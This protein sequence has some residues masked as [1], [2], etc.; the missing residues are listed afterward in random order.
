MAGFRGR[1]VF[2]IEWSRHNITLKIPVKAIPSHDYT[3]GKNGLTFE[4]VF[5]DAGIDER[6]TDINKLKESVFEKLDRWYS[7]DWD[8]YFLV[9]V[10]GGESDYGCTRLE[11]RTF[12]RFRIEFEVEFYVV[13]KDMRGVVR[14]MRIPRPEKI[15]DFKDTRWAGE[16]PRDG[17]PE[18][19]KFAASKV[20]GASKDTRA[21][22]KATPG[23]VAA[24]DR[25]LATMADL[26]KKMHDHFS[27]DVIERTLARASQL[28]LP[29]PK[30]SK[31]A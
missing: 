7:I 9:T 27:P 23:N 13:G 31:D 1:K 8:L 21:L 4:A 14:H 17:L 26:L 10:N 30:G 22:V 29:A 28:L 3:T 11:N 19:R 18:T 12:N 20:Y 24:A 5:A 16:N 6:N 15:A 25:F 2:D